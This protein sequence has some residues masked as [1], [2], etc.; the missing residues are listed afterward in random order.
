LTGNDLNA[1]YGSLS[2]SEKP[3]PMT[4]WAVMPR[5]WSDSH[6]Y[7]NRWIGGMAAMVQHPGLRVLYLDDGASASVDMRNRVIVNAGMAYVLDGSALSSAG[8]PAHRNTNY[9]GWTGGVIHALAPGDTL[10][11]SAATGVQDGCTPPDGF[12]LSAPYP[13]PFNPATT[14]AFETQRAGYVALAVFNSLGQHVETLIDEARPAGAW[15]VQWRAGDHPSGRYFF[16]LSQ[17]G[18]QRVQRGLY[19]K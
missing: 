17:G 7:E 5:L 14:L 16:R 4:G 13:N 15:R 18:Q 1:W 10:A 2:F 9:C 12:S 19:L 3:G 6:H 8:F 11:L